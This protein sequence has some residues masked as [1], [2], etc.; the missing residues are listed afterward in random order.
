MKVVP[1]TVNSRED[2]GKIYEMGVDGIITDRPWVLREFL[3]ERGEKLPPA[4]SV[5]LPYHLEPDH[6]TADDKKADN[7]RDAAY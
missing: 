4:R 5:D 7:G 2:I 6:Y 3:E 1:W